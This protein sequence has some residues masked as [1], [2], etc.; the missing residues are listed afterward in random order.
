MTDQ[1]RM[2]PRSGKSNVISM[3]ADRRAILKEMGVP[4][5]LLIASLQRGVAEKR[6]AMFADPPTAGGYDLF[7][8]T[9][10]HV[11]TGLFERGWEVRNIANIATVRN[12]EDGT[13]IIVCA[14]DHQTGM[15]IGSDPKT[16]RPKGEIFLDVSDVASLDL[17]GNPIPAKRKVMSES[18]KVWLLLHY[19]SEF[20]GEEIFRAELSKPSVAEA[21]L[22]TT[23][24]QRIILNTTLPDSIHDDDTADDSGPEI[25][26]NVTI[27]I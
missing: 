21:G 17:F 10:R 9:T 5:D 14:G 8:Y 19:H 11:R 25:L 16:K 1:T 23:W 15:I 26:P 24:S 3:P 22:I 20:A 13:T 4:E 2:S 12:P 6:T 7:R 18:S 27:R